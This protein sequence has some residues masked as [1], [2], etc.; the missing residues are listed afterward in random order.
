MK[1]LW[2]FVGKLAY[3]V[4]RP[5]MYVLRN[6]SFLSK[7]RVRVVLK[8]PQGE[9]LLVRT[10]FGQQ[11]WSFPGGG[12]GR[13]ETD[14]AAAIREVLEETGVRLAETQLRYIGK[15]TRN[16]AIPFTLKI[17]EASLEDTTLSPLS[18]PRNLEITD[19]VWW[20]PK[21]TKPHLSQSVQ[22][23]LD[24]FGDSA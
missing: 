2:L 1:R 5:V 8:G 3:I 17:Y 22:W 11:K 16:E 4:A 14:T 20:H 7:P 10:W 21:D 23:Y 6:Q 24:R 19:R 18:L 15:I 13:G 9:L 12:V